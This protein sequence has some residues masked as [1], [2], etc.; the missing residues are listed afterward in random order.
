VTD[1]PLL[2]TV[3]ASLA[4]IGVDV[5]TVEEDPNRTLA[6]PPGREPRS[7]V[8]DGLEVVG[9]LGQGAMGVVH[10]ATQQTLG[11]RVA[12]KSLRADHRS[13]RATA[14]LLREAWITGA[15]EHPHVI[16]VHDIARGPDGEPWV[17]LKKV[18]GTDWAALI[19][20]PAQI[21]ERFGAEDP[22]EWNLNVFLRV[23]DAM[24]FAH[25][26]GIL[27]RD[28]KPENV[29]I[30]RTGEVYVVDWGLAV[31]LEDDG[32][33]RF[34]LA[35]DAHQLAGTPA[36]M[37]PEMLGGRAAEL[38]AR[39]DVYLLG[40]LLHH[41]VKGRPPHRGNNFAQ[42]V[43]A[44]ALSDPSIPDDAP[45]ELMTIVRDAMQPDPA[46]RVD[47]VERLADRVRDYL[48]HRGA[49]A[50]AHRAERSRQALERALRDPHAPVERVYDLFSDC[51]FAF[52]HSLEIWPDRR[53]TR[54]GLDLALETMARWELERGQPE[55]A[56]RLLLRHGAPPAELSES[57]ERA[58]SAQRR[59]T[60]RLHAIRDAFD[61][62]TGLRGR[63]WIGAIVGAAI[64]AQP[65]VTGALHDL[66]VLVATPLSLLVRNAVLLAIVSGVALW[67]RESL[68]TSKMNRVM[69]VAML[70]VVLAQGLVRGVG[71]IIDA[72]VA[73]TTRGQFPIWFAVVLTVAAAVDRWFLVP[74]VTY[75]A[76]YVVLAFFPQL[77]FYCVGVGNVVLVATVF[78]IVWKTG[79]A[80]GRDDRGLP[81]GRAQP[82]DP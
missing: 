2:S 11:R 74:A 29:M 26:R 51:R 77:G 38:S 67:M 4:E 72:G 50:L 52:E 40:G 34:P 73:E 33:G 5:A 46:A 36:Y 71:L 57:I 61:P 24:H 7:T 6:P 27:H 78:A 25:G 1:D 22:L 58:R 66:G 44:I 28:L 41:I 43:S 82:G 80:P 48:R 31:A 62:R 18:D 23:C 56:E 3:A 75:G 15:L 17:V 63:F 64:I 32:T 69:I 54:E 39:T 45:A 81:A 13:E 19:D 68:R 55:A 14:K 47:S 65:F 30:G 76:G 35:R 70:S 8:A 12:V 49:V 20:D 37:A 53:S 42:I 21:L 59:E 16:P 9:V 10:E 79:R 60:A